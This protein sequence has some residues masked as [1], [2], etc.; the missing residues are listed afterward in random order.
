VVHVASRRNL[1]QAE[2]SGEDGSLLA[3]TATR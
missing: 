1:R 3:Q 2:A